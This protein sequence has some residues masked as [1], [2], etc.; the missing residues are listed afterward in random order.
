MKKVLLIN[1]SP[2]FNGETRTALSMV[3]TALKEKGIGSEW[4]QLGTEPVRSGHLLALGSKR[5]T[6]SA[7]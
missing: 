5:D 6:G 3:E 2:R 4:F 1:G 7:Y